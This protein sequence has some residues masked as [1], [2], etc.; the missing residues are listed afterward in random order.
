MLV[1]I[2]VSAI[3]L[4]I[5]AVPMIQGF[6][7]TRSGQAYADAQAAARYV[8]D[9]VLGDIG[10][11]AGIR[12]G[13]GPMGGLNLDLPAPFGTVN[14]TGVKI[15]IF[16]PAE[17]DPVRG[18]SGAF[19]NPETG[20]EDPTYN[21]PQGQVNVPAAPGMSI[22]RYWIGLREPLRDTDGNGEPNNNPYND[23]YSG[24]LM[25]RNAQRDNLFVLYRAEVEPMVYDST[26]GQY[27]VNAD[28]FM[29]DDLDGQPDYDDPDF[30]RIGALDMAAGTLTP[31]GQQKVRQINNW[32]TRG[33]IVTQI[34]RYDMIQA[35]YD[36]QTKQLYGDARDGLVPLIRFQGVIVSDEAVKGERALR[37][38]EETDNPSKVGPDVY[39]TTRGHWFGGKVKVF[40]G[41][42]LTPTGPGAQSSGGYVRPPSMSSYPILSYAPPSGG[43]TGFIECQVSPGDLPTAAM[44]NLDLYMEMKES[45]VAYPFPAALLSADNEN[46]ARLIPGAR[47]DAF[48]I[49]EFVPFYINRKDNRGAVI[50]SFDIQ[51]VG[52]DVSGPYA[53]WE[54]RVPSDGADPGVDTGPADTPNSDLNISAPGSAWSNADT[55][56]T[57]NNRFNNVWARW[58]DFAPAL[59][60]ARFAKRF[61]DLAR[62]NQ[63]GGDPSPLNRL[64]GMARAYITP[65]SEKV[66]GP[67]QR[68]GPNYGNL[69]RYT[70]VATRPVGPNQYFMNYTDMPEPDWNAALGSGVSYDPKVFNSSDFVSAVLQP[71][72][73]A[74]YVELNSR[75]GEPIPQGNVYVSYKFQFT[76][77]NDRVVVDYN[78]GE[79]IEV[80]LTIKNFPQSNI[81][82]PQ[83]V[84]VKGSTKVRNYIR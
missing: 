70:R 6:N 60:R 24:I 58:N 37:L 10:N 3:L 9:L 21:A 2:A 29:D 72:Y 69:V 8:R 32:R 43:G 63:P 59:D 47:L 49:D 26:L 50:T 13:G 78:S 1:V 18:P 22:V 83:S 34:N 23:P 44:F 25:A 76:E 20:M 51:D 36:P 71:Q 75:F 7:L 79:A 4:T 81:P 73:R 68:P 62:V 30:F 35:K 46:I 40:A 48:H 66:Y 27:V 14:F 41:T 57:I 82:F 65:G 19:I 33:S 38:G 15:D 56:R 67:D 77:P 16:L 39:R 11:S 42:Y 54:N 61:I 74:G 64:N 53:S 31:R 12:L 80:V 55:F 5:I 45:G 17:G 28:F 52:S 84:T